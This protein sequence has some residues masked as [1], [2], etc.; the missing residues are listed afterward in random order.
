MRTANQA[1][2]KIENPI[3]PKFVFCLDMTSQSDQVALWHN[4]Y[5][6][7]YQKF[8]APFARKLIEAGRDE[9]KKLGY[10]PENSIINGVSPEKGVVWS[11]FLPER[12]RT[13][14]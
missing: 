7:K 9:C 1:K 5:D 11:N 13:D 8:L 3:N 10:D 12:I 6:F 2:N 14:R 4:T